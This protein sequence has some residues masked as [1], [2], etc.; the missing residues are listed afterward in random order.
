MSQET[1][2]YLAYVLRNNRSVLELLDS[3]YTFLN[4]TLARHYG[5]EGVVGDEFRKGG[6]GRSAVGRCLDASER[7][8]P[9]FEPQSDLT[10][11]AG[12]MDLAAGARDT[13]STAASRSP[14]A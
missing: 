8:D 11:Q 14:Q 9:D 3:N 1:E 5:I 12:A 13:P 7:T 2:R 4:A 10:G 6:T